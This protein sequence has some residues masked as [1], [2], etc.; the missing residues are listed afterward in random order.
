MKSLNQSQIGGFIGLLNLLIIF[1]IYV[2]MGSELSSEIPQTLENF[3]DLYMKFSIM[4]AMLSILMIFSY[5]DSNSLITIINI[6]YI[7][8]YILVSKLATYA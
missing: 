4:P 8:I 6:V 7:I 1:I 3:Y 5:D 2:Q